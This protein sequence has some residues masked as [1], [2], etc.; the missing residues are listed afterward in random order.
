MNI[1][2]HENTGMNVKEVESYKKAKNQLFVIRTAGYVLSIG[3]FFFT[4]SIQNIN[5][6]DCLLNKCANFFSFFSDNFSLF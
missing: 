5:S 4:G 3:F 1:V 6:L 2:Y